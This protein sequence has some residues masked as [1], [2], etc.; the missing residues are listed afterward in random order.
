MMGGATTRLRLR[1]SAFSN[2]RLPAP[3]LRLRRSKSSLRQP[4]RRLN[5]PYPRHLSHRVLGRPS[6]PKSI[7]EWLPWALRLSRGTHWRLVRISLRLKAGGGD[8]F[9]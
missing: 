5:Q 3:H 1:A 7:C 9:R 2:H 6:R 4:R 8:A